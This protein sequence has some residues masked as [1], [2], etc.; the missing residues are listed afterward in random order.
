[1]RIFD[2]ETLGQIEHKGFNQDLALGD[3]YMA[4][5]AE[6][7]RLALLALGGIGYLLKS[8]SFSGDNKILLAVA[9]LMGLC[10]AFALSHRYVT[11]DLLACQL[12]L[13]RL[14]TRGLNDDQKKVTKEAAARNRRLSLA[15]PLLVLSASF[16]AAGAAVFV[17]ALF[18]DFANSR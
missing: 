1:M 12:R 6:L 15:G 17:V 13:V 3:R 14:C 5:S 11:C 8:R 18:N 16:L 9:I 7:L 2:A 10:T 4:F